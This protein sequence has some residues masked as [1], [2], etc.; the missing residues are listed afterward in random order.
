MNSERVAIVYTPSI[1]SLFIS[2]ISK[3]WSLKSGI[4]SLCHNTY[5][6]YGLNGWFGD[7]NIACYS[8]SV[9]VQVRTPPLS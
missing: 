6:M 9:V 3:W 7:V 5:S 4:D 2:C 8:V 1:L